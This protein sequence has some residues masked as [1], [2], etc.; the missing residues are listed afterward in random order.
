MDQSI[1]VLD[2]MINAEAH[3]F[4]EWS[5]KCTWY[6]SFAH[7]SLT[8]LVSSC[9]PVSMSVIDEIFMLYLQ[10]AVSWCLWNIHVIHK[11][12]RINSN[13][14]SV[15]TCERISIG[16]TFFAF[17]SAPSCT[18]CMHALVQ[19]PPLETCVYAHYLQHLD[20]NT[21]IGKQWLLGS[22]WS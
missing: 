8:N 17:S 7:L 13:L 11:Y 4:V 16:W 2:W 9:K 21:L 10:I 19:M 20:P 6:R 14:E 15:S 18:P 5:I 12:S 1:L 3:H 22:N